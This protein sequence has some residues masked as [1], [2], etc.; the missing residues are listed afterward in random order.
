MA[1]K[2]AP[3]T[4]FRTNKYTSAFQELINAY[5]VATYR[6]INPAVFTIVTFPFLFAIMF[7]DAGHG[8]I[9]FGAAMWCILKEKRLMS[10]KIDNEIWNIFFG[11]RYIIALMGIFSIYTGLIYNDIFSKSLNLFGSQWQVTMRCNDIVNENSKGRITMMIDPAPHRYNDTTILKGYAGQPYPFGVDPVWQVATNKIVFLN[12][13]K[14]KISIIIGVIHMLFGVLLSLWNNKYFK[15]AINIYCEFIPQLIFLICMFGYMSLLM[16][17]KWTAYVA[18]GFP[19]QPDL[20]ER[21]APSILISFINMVLFK[22]ND[23]AGTFLDKDGQKMPCDPYMY[24]GQHALQ[25]LLIILAM[26]S[27]PWMLL[28]KPFLLRKQEKEK[29]GSVL[30]DDNGKFDFVEVVILQGIHTIEYVLG[31]VSHTASYLRLWALSLAHAQ[32]SEVLWNMVLRVGLGSLDRRYGGIVLWAVFA[33][34]AVLTVG[35][36]CLMEGLSAFLHTLRLH[37]VEFQSKFYSGQGHLFIP[38]SFHNI[39]KQ[40]EEMD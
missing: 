9:M 14:M 16:F 30:M 33:A 38:F 40:A 13:F 17:H 1:T 15:K 39:L 27:V 21:C 29:P 6:E 18:G 8:L 26:I 22:V 20:S 31:S 24:L 2:E 28:T 25:Y 7:G 19:G 3:P 34:W 36:L 32:L 5:G 11:G 35:I 12:A 10:K 37:W 4:F 23:P